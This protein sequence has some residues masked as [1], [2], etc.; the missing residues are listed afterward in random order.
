ME[1]DEWIMVFESDSILCFCRSYF[2]FAML[3]EDFDDDDDDDGFAS[4]D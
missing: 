2:D 1:E 3:R 4:I